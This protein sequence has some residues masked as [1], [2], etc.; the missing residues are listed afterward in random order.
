[1]IGL[2]FGYAW[3]LIQPAIPGT[4]Q[5]VEAV[6]KGGNRRIWIWAALVLVVLLVAVIYRRPLLATWY[7]NLGAVEQTRLELSRYNP[8]QFDKYS[9]DQTRRDGWQDGSLAP[10]LANF[11][12]AL[13]MD[14]QQ[15]TALQ[16]RA[17]IA[18]S[19]GEYTAALEDTTR[20]WQAGNRDDVTRLLHGDALVANGRPEPAV[21]AVGGLT[22]AKP[23]LQFQ[24]WYRY[25]IHQ[26]YRRAA[27]AWKAVLLLDP[28]TPD[29]DRWL[30]QAQEK[31]R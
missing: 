5:A 20:L 27:D 19:R 6:G 4:A 10:A 23:R 21:D 11:Q 28:Q 31:L 18:L 30:K 26:D 25:W 29:I 2:L 3:F 7:A 22:W 12:R 13:A 1:L 9:L 17:Q 16:R 14:P 15:P 8:Y 24:A